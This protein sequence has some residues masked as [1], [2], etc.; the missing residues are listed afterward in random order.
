M[1]FSRVLGFL[2]FLLWFAI[3]R[4]SCGQTPPSWLDISPGTVYKPPADPSCF[5]ITV[6]DG[7]FMTVDLE[8]YLQG[9]G[10]QY[11]FGW[12]A[13]DGNGQAQICI[14]ASTLEGHYEFT[15]VRNSELYW[16]SFVP[17][18]SVLDVISTPPVIYA[19]GPGGDNWDA[20][21][22]VGARFLPDSYVYV[23]SPGWSSYQV[24][25]GPAWGWSPGLWVSPDGSLITLQVTDPAVRNAFGNSGAYVAVMSGD[26]T[27]SQWAYTQSPPPVI[28]SGGPGCDDGYCIW[29]TGYFPLD[30]TVDLRIPGES[31]VLSNA[32]SDLNVAS[33]GLTLRLDPSVRHA[34]DVSGLN[35][36]V[37]NPLLG[38]WSGGYFVPPVDRAIN[39]SIDGIVRSGLEY[40]VNGWA[41]AKTYPG[42]IDIHV[43]VGGPAG[44]GGTFVGS[45]T[46]N[47]ASEPGVA[48]ACNSTGANY[49]FSLLLPLA[50]R[51][52]YGGQP[53]YVHGISPFGLANSWIG[54]SGSF[55]IPPVD[56]SIN[57][58]IDGIFQSGQDY[59]L[60][61]WA[62]AKSSPSSIDVHV[63][64]GGPAGGGGT[65]ALAGTANQASEPG[66]ATACDA[67]G[68]NYRFS[69]L[70]SPALRDQYGGQRI[71]VHGISPFGLANS[72]L[73]H[74]GIP[75]VPGAGS[76]LSREYIYLGERI[77]AADAP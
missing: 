47:L 65:F 54:G 27:A 66:V 7:A 26:G 74:S 33:T 43:Y 50:L 55:A 57:G 5:T 48:A 60:Y 68:S 41:C 16:E 12:P 67:T 63:Y 72:L 64:V 71:F 73:G 75:M 34:F 30:A 40:D 10:P 1:T 14:D 70:L 77:L 53:I 37:V 21:W 15:G 4:A 39:G 32:Y 2:A 24:I 25:W 17:A 59:F 19:L 61:G 28:S 3:P 8:Y 13:L 22:I 6:G 9:S 62:C 45:A 46:A 56:R 23:V 69:F 49:R 18:Y 38:N 35:A 31:N 29:L 20:I 76:N 58:N 36:W 42:S 44:G 11:V 51:E 52:Q